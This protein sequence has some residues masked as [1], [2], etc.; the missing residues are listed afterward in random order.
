MVK[1]N[2]NFMLIILILDLNLVNMQRIS[3]KLKTK[4]TVRL[5]KFLTHCIHL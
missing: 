1:Q 3:L 4:C 2:L 5:V